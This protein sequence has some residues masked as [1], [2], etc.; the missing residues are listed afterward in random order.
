MCKIS[1]SRKISCAVHIL[2][3][4]AMRFSVGFLQIIFIS[5][6]P[7]IIYFGLLMCEE[8]KSILIFFLTC[9]ITI[10]TFIQI[11]FV[12]SGRMSVTYVEVR[13]LLLVSVVISIFFLMKHDLVT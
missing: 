3:P 6:F 5:Y 12:P 2:T 4:A 13:N 1:V 10:V 7:Q 9:G 8:K 11:P